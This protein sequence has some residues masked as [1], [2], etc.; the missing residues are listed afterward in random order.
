MQAGAPLAPGVSQQAFK[1]GTGI[2]VARVIAARVTPASEIP[3][4]GAGSGD[5]VREADRLVGRPVHVERA[6]GVGRVFGFLSSPL[7]DRLAA[8]MR[9]LSA[10][11]DERSGGRNHGASAT[12]T[13][14]RIGRRGRR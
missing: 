3:L 8:L 9:R 2:R 12:E 7:P 1:H 14:S 5:Q 11:R 13:S 10:D 4:D 6:L